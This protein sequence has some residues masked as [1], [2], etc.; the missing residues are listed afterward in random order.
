MHQYISIKCDSSEGFETPNTSNWLGRGGLISWPSRLPVFCPL[1]LVYWGNVKKR[2]FYLWDET[3]SL[4]C[5][6]ERTYCSSRSWYE[7]QSDG[8]MMILTGESRRTL[9]KTCP[10]A[11]FST[12]NPTWID[13]GAN[14][15]LR[16]ERSVT[17]RLSRGMVQRRVLLLIKAIYVSSYKDICRKLHSL[18]QRWY[19]PVALI[20]FPLWHYSPR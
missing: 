6:H 13:P 9:R 2:V 19:T 17:N 18:I 20:L 15:G 4:N 10:S 12:T 5:C 8:G 16:G 11:I 14:P 7:L 1:H 3:T